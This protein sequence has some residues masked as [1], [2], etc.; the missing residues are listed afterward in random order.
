MDKIKRILQSQTQGLHQAAY[1]LGFFAVLSQLCALIRDRLLAHTFGAGV[2]LDIYYSA[3]RLPDIMFVL[4]VTFFSV[5]VLV[6]LIVERLNNKKELKRYFD[7]VFTF[8]CLCAIVIFVGAWISAPYFLKLLVP[9]LFNQYSDTIVSITRILLIQPLLLS[10]SGFFGS[11]AQAQKHFLL[12]ALSPVMYNIGII[13][14]IVILYPLFGLIGLGF[15]VVSGAFLHLIILLP[16]VLKTYTPRFSK[17]YFTDIKYLIFHSIPRTFSLLSNQLLLVCITFFAGLLVTGSIAIFNFSYNLQSVPLAIIGVSYSL[18]AFPTL[19]LF[20]KEKKFDEFYELLSRAVRHV[21]FW[22][23]PVM[24]LF[25]VLR[26][27]IVRTVL[28]SGNFDW[29]ETMLVAAALA[30]F[31]LSI[32]TQSASSVLIR[33]YYAMNR[34]FY[35]FVCVFISFLITIACMCVL[36]IPGIKDSSFMFYVENFLKVENTVSSLVLII[37]M[38]FT[39]GQWVQ[40]TLLILGMRQLKIL[41]SKQF[42]I[43]ISQ[44]LLGAGTIAIVAYFM[45]QFLSGVF[46]LNTFLGI[47]F[48]GFFAGVSGIFAGII[49]LLLIGNKEIQT[50]VHVGFKKLKQQ[51]IL[52]PEIREEL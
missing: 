24:A 14:G 17:I 5:S 36:F 20:F 31:T 28:G 16:I 47:A 7:S 22:S 52:Q 19:A 43:S 33:A 50:I 42:M 41:F 21:F 15:G 10:L 25:I 32:V 44:S 2:E 45:L 9:E 4:L 6:P 8:V 38:A 49:F 48:Q 34:T 11:F 29:N 30:I 23:L 39:V 27:Q 46:D 37:P 1:L 18:A 12:Y 26:A 3:F 51:T 40:F 13:L 35:P